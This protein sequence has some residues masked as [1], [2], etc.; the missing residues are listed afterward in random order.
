MNLRFACPVCG[1]ECHPIAEEGNRVKFYCPTCDESDWVVQVNP[2]TFTISPNSFD[3]FVGSSDPTED[4]ALK[5]KYR[6][7]AEN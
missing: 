1:K 3:A 6:D 2:L 7:G 4:I 5:S